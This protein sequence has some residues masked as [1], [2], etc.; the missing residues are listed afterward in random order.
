AIVF[1]WVIGEYL[2]AM[3]GKPIGLKSVWSGFP[4]ELFLT[5]VGITALFAQAQTNGTM[6][7][8]AR[9]GVRCCRG[10]SGFMPLMFFGLALGIA[11]IGAGNMASAALVGPLA[12]AVA[13]RIGIP[14][15]LM[16]VMVA[17]GAV[18]GA[19]SPFAPT[20]LI[21]ANLMRRMGLPGHE[22]PIYLYNLLANLLV[23][24]IGYFAFGGWQ[25]LNSKRQ[26]HE[27]ATALETCAS[28]HLP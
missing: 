1:A 2:G 7:R 10:N 11:S 5:L 23:A 19:L 15:L 18:A 14:A 3:T 17:H 21:A 12:M 22:W 24:S 26:S 13:G 20:G 27:N 4:T 8:L 25:L 16:A 9:F 28:A 6:E